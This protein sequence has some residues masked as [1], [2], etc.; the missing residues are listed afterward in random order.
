MIFLVLFIGLI[1]SINSCQKEEIFPIDEEQTLNTTLKTSSVLI[2]KAQ[3]WFE[4]NPELNDYQLINSIKELNWNTAIVHDLDS[5]KI[6]EV[7]IKLKDHH[8]FKIKDKEA[9]NVEPRLLIINR[10]GQYYSSMEFIIS[11]DSKE[12]IRNIKKI[13]YG[14]RENDFTGTFLYVNT[15]GEISTEQFTNNQNLKSNLKTELKSCLVHAWEYE[16]LPGLI[17]IDV[18]CYEDIVTG[19]ISPIIPPPGT[20]SNPSGGT[21]SPNTNECPYPKCPNHGCD[22]YI[23]ES[24]KSVPS[25]D[26]ATSEE[27]TVLCPSCTCPDDP[28][29]DDPSLEV[30]CSGDPVN[31]PEIAPTQN[32]SYSG[33]M[34]GCNRITDDD[35]VQGTYNKWHNGVDIKCDLNS[36]L[37]AMYDGTI[38][39]TGT[40]ADLGKWVRVQSIVGGEV[41]TIQYGHLSDILVVKGA[42][43]LARKVIARSGDTGNAGDS[44]AVPH[45]H[46]KSYSGWNLIETNPRTLFTSTFSQ[47]G[48]TLI[49]CINTLNL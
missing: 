41:I 9:L 15:T 8:K 32:G 11:T 48:E 39:D 27:I 29:S 44:A 43:V 34:Y 31:N 38:L 28:S 14:N 22:G 18:Y 30:P 20:T 1:V 47:A 21:T 5:A 2:E 7:S 25:C 35:C 23:F 16:H 10:E 42:T 46:V 24:F 40:S 17:W 4:E 12:N 13:N 36:P 3:K 33:G 37:Y 49:S 6:S 19:E 45:V 26:D